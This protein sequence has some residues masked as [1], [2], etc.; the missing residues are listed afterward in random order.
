[1]MP[2]VTTELH[3]ICAQLRI[4]DANRFLFRGWELQL[5]ANGGSDGEAATKVSATAPTGADGPMVNRL[6]QLLYAA[7]YVRNADFVPAEF[8]PQQA[9]PANPAAENLTPLLMQA[10][11]TPEGWDQGWKIYHLGSNG[12]AFVKKG[13]RSRVA[14]AGTYALQKWSDT[15]PRL[16]DLV[17]LRVYPGTSD[18]QTAFLHTFGATLSDQFDDFNT[19]RFYFNIK[20]DAAS[21]LLAALGAALN[22][23]FI[24][25]HFKTLVDPAMYRRADAAV[26]YFARRYYHMVAAIVASLPAILGDGLRTATPLFTKTFMPGIGIA[27]DPGTGDSFGM[28]RCN[29]VAQGLVDAWLAGA[30]AADASLAAIQNRLVRYGLNPQALW[31]NPRSTDIF[32]PAGEH[33]P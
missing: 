4:V 26:L 1:M 28:H 33:L 7:C 22:H 9:K 20:H 29:L 6:C 15:G 24:P 32:V 2:D 21:A 13:E 10:N 8:E 18:L 19:V 25:F 31:L 23:Y 16:G 14:M 12:R 17:S 30:Q 5:K 11:P 3:D 27:E